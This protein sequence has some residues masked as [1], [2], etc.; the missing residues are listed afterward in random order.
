MKLVAHRRISQ[1][2]LSKPAA[3]YTLCR[4][5]H[6]RIS[7]LQLERDVGNREREAFLGERGVQV[8]LN[9][10]VDVPWAKCPVCARACLF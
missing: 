10:S 9:T 2:S 1:G 3:G 7:L 4:S 6:A 5:E 8:N